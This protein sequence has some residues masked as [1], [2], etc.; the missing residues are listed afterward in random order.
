MKKERFFVPIE[1]EFAVTQ[2]YAE[3]LVASFSP[4]L[5]TSNSNLRRGKYAV[6]AYNNETAFPIINFADGG[7]VMLAED[8]RTNPIIGFSKK[9]TFDIKGKNLPKRLHFWLDTSKKYMM[10]IRNSIEDEKE[11]AWKMETMMFKS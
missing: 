7:F 2:E 8:R 3:N 9:S 1:S 10:A 5:N 4:D 6:E 11:S